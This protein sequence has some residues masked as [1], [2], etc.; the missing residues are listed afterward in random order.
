MTTRPKD[1]R[2]IRRNAV[3]LLGMFAFVF[4]LASDLTWLA[5]AVLLVSMTTFF[6]MWIK[7]K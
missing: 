7:D 4:L 1:I 3:G 2:A 5:G 6:W